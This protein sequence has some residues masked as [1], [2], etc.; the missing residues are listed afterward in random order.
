MKLFLQLSYVMAIVVTFNLSTFGQ[1]QF[2]VKING[3]VSKITES[4][5]NPNISF[6]TPFVPSGQAGL[7]Y[8]LLIS[9]NT[10]L[11]AELL[12]SQIEGK[13]ISELRLIDV[14]GNNVGFA[15]THTYRHIS[16]LIL[17]VYFGFNLQKLTIHAGFQLSYNIAG[18]DKYKTDATVNGERFKSESTSEN[19]PFS[20]YE[21]GPRTGIYYHLTDRLAVEGIYYF[22][23]SNIEKGVP[24]INELKVQQMTVGVR[25]ALGSK[26]TTK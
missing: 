25:Y 18:S 8:N 14:E 24:M 19:N 15:T 6:V 9:K 5:E 13:E 22:G 1:R 4:R 7:Y 12:F 17:P 11:G 3:G 2:G 20:K 10:A 21:F 16:Y 23:I 26:M